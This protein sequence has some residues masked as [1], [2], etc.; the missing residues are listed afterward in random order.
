MRTTTLFLEPTQELY[1]NLGERLGLRVTS[2][3]EPTQELYLNSVLNSKTSPTLYLE[4]TQELYLNIRVV[5][6]VKK[7]ET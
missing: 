2:T 1:L 7:K 5:W 6:Q 3:L 4:P